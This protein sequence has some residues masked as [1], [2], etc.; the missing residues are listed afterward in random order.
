MI[1]HHQD[2]ERDEGQW[3]PTGIVHRRAARRESKLQPA[4]ICWNSIFDRRA[5]PIELHLS[6]PRPSWPRATKPRPTNNRAARS[7]QNL[8]FCYGS[9]RLPARFCAAFFSCMRCPMQRRSLKLA[10][11]LAKQLA[12]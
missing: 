3:R 1:S 12:K 11:Q 2:I 7:D 4:P 8:V 9:G 6:F 5:H 10:K